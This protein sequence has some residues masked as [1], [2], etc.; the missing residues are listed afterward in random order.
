MWYNQLRNN[1]VTRAKTTC[2]IFKR[3]KFFYNADKMNS[4]GRN[5]QENVDV[6]RRA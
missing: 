4:G 1:T 5:F 3:K 2:E 6:K